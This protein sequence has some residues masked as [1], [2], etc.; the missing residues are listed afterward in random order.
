MTVHA[1]TQVY[2][3]SRESGASASVRRQHLAGLPSWP[4]G[5]VLAGYP[6]WWVLGIGDLALVLAA[7]AMVHQLLRRR[8]RPVVPAGFGVWLLFLAWV[9]I[10]VVGLDSGARLLG[11]GY[12]ALIYIAATIVFIYIYSDR[13]TFTI[14]RVA[15]L[16]TGFW[17]TMVVGGY[18]GMIWPLFT[19]RTPMSY[20]LPGGLLSNE[21][22]NEMAVRR[23]TQFNPDSWV[24]LTPRP[25]APF[26]YTNG[27]GNAYSILTPVV[28]AY[29]FSLSGWR[30]S[31]LVLAVVASLAPA[32]LSLNRGMF[33]GLGIAGVYI[34]I[35]SFAAGH[36]RVLVGVAAAGIVAAIAVS[37]LP[38]QDRLSSRLES[39]STT[40]DR[41]SLYEETLERSLE[42]PILGYGAPRPSEAA[43]LPAT[44]TQG[45]IW[46]LIFSHGIP[47]A[48]LFAAWLIIAFAHTWAHRSAIG[49][50]MHTAT[51][52]MLV[53][54]FYYGFVHMGLALL[55]AMIAAAW[56]PSG[57][58]SSARL[59]GSACRA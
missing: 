57:R 27:W 5:I 49:L 19:L 24:V 2:A 45:H 50:A 46:M 6:I 8:V 26:L 39:S 52:V 7:V 36:S 56:L 37:V 32:L 13:R 12:R 11:F 33:V 21:L 17:G 18:L 35:R 31:M 14:E 44:G 4:L 38:V 25:S 1:P 16:L 59:A 15:G 54:I 40:E 9:A 55:M 29:A 51:L 34:A 3:L 28:I 43:G 10:S 42:S 58:V 47:A 23:F 41:A 30:R 48:I 22:V 20:L 53:E